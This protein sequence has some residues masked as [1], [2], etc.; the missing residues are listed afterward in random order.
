MAAVEA[1]ADAVGVVLAPSKRRVTLEEALD[2][3]RDVPPSVAR[4]G[5]F[6][7]ASAEEVGE[8][9]RYLGLDG[10]QL[11]GSE[12]PEAC[13]MTPLSAATI[14]SVRVGPDFE[15]ASLDAY[16]GSVEAFLLDTYVPG[17]QGGTGVA[18]EWRSIAGRLP[19]WALCGLAGGLSPANV[20]EAIR[21]LRP[22]GVDVS[23]GVEDAPGVKNHDAIREFVA[24]VRATDM[25]V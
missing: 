24:A 22:F 6:V 17:E 8:A 19:S 21:V 15:V 16:R 10:V 4:I 14:K 7:D 25:E 1:G 23:S 13:R 3:L 18:F 5:V 2:V 9:V 20:G 12:T 11:H